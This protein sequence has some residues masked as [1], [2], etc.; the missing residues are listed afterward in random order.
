MKELIQFN[1][2]AFGPLNGLKFS[3]GV[4]VL[5]VAQNLTGESWMITGLVALF[6]WMANIPGPLKARIGG[7]VG[8]ALGAMFCAL[9]ASMIGS[10]Q[11]IGIIALS[12]IGLLGT[13]ATLWGSRAGMVGWAIVIYMIYAP[14]FVAGIGLE[15]SI[16]AI[17]LGVGVLFFLNVLGTV[18][19]PDSGEE[20]EGAGEVDRDSGYIAAYAL[21]A[22]VVLAL[23]S[24]IGQTI[25]TD[26]LMVTAGAF[27]VIGFDLHKTWV[28]GVA[29][30]IG[31]SLGILLAAL[32]VLQIG[33]G[34][35]LQIFLVVISFLVFAT[36]PIHP[37]FLMLFLT[38]FLASGWQSLQ[39][40][41]LELTINEKFVGEFA[42]VVTALAAIFLLKFWDKHRSNENRATTI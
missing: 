27:F 5:M 23:G 17:L 3:V 13:A 37:S 2:K 18:M 12:V 14:S 4:V 41:A 40:E 24:W 9:L 34:M 11:L 28:G 31:I 39:T 32:I 36:A 30:L 15:N 10:Q 29:R 16:L 6:A 42:G 20:A 33:P 22:A 8:F 7:M 25:K 1:W 19:N 26:P 21:I 35:P 38:V